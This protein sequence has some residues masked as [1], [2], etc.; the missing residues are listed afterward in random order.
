MTGVKFVRSKVKRRPPTLDETTVN[1]STELRYVLVCD[2]EAHI[3][4]VISAKLSGSGLAVKQARTGAEGLALA[5]EHAPMLIIT[6]FQM[7]VMSGLEM[8][9]QLKA[10]P[11]CANVPL[12]MLTARGYTLDAIELARTNIRE[13][14]AKP[15]G[16]KQ[17]MERV[18]SILSVLPS[19]PTITQP[20]MDGRAA[21]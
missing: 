17:L 3:R 13:V 19:V 8:A 16:V 1:S 21:A 20:A 5:L 10:S 7:P 6:D 9:Q 18:T 14:V 4:A 12:L 15:F 2:D 11:L